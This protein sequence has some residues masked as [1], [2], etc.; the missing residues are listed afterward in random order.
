MKNLIIQSLANLADYEASKRE[1]GYQFKVAMYKKAMKAFKNR[2]TPKTFEDAS[3]ILMETFKNPSKIT[4][5]I[6]E[7]YET[8]AISAVNKAKSDPTAQ[9][10]ILLSSVPQIGQV[11]ARTLVKQHN[12]L[13]ISQ[14]KENKSLLNEKQKLG[15]KYYD[16]LIDPKTLDAVRIPRSEIKKFEK[17]LKAHL[18]SDLQYEICGSYRRGVETSG[19]IDVLFTGNNKS[20]NELIAKLT[21]IQL[22]KD[23][24]SHGKSKWM[25]MG[26]ISKLHRRIDLMFI[27]SDK[28]PFALLYFTGSQEFNEQ[29]RGYARKLGYT[30]NEHGIKSI[31]NSKINETF[32]TEHDIFKFLGV[33]Y[34]IPEKRK[35]GKFELPKLQ[36]KQIS[37][38]IKLL[39]TMKTPKDI[40]ECLKGKGAGGYSVGELRELSKSKTGTKK[41]LCEKLFPK[42]VNKNISNV[43]NVS[44][45]VLLAATY[46]TSIDPTGYIASEKYDGVRAIWDGKN[47]KSRTNKK[48]YAPEWFTSFLPKDHSLDGEL[49]I[50]RGMFEKTTSVVS[51][52][53][54]I[55]NEWKNIKYMV[56]DVPSYSAVFVERLKLLKSIV[57]KSC[58]SE[59]CPLMYAHHFEI[60]NKSQMMTMYQKIIEQGGEGIMLRL[61]QSKYEQ[62][63]SK[64]LLKVKPTDDDEAVIVNMIEGRGKD[65]GSM[66]ALVVHLQKNPTVQF[67]IGTGFTSNVRKEFWKKKNNHMGSIVTFGYK[68]LT[69]KGVPRHPSYIRMKTNAKM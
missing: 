4:A 5:K 3:S 51:K 6:K 48:I 64:T 50:A 34:V 62:K 9:A 53:V 26:L 65:A 38:S 67:K 1:K 19:D 16:E 8:G 55:D 52:K 41:E 2:N 17:V 57:K 7:L 10:I 59:K 45:G 11:K 18:P 15:L 22:I 33:K 37:S 23:P 58:T 61:P 14:L 49:Y 40:I 21:N 69:A 28:Y 47:L 31:E 44:K 24:F 43:F 30:L 25:G 46:D 35:Q 66:G 29:F 20:Y 63:R 42:S 36:E 39:S 54:P 13:T 56:F 12:I 60:K 68:G 27:P 32:K